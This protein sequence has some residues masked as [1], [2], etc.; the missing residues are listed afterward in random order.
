MKAFLEK[1]DL[2]C[3]YPEFVKTKFISYTWTL[4]R[5]NQNDKLKFLL[6]WISELKYEF[7]QG[8]F[9]K[10]FWDDYNWNLIHSLIFDFER[11]CNC[12]SRN[13]GVEF[14]FPNPDNLIKNVAPVYIYGAGKFA[15]KALKSLR[16]KEIKVTAFVVTDINNN[17]SSIDGIP[18]IELDKMD[19]DGLIYIGVSDKFKNEIIAL[20]KEKW[21][22]PNVFEI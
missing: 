11:T 12:I 20:L 16:E 21:L 19:K 22:L 3:F 4:A 15:L 18:V 8:Y 9:K 5:L 2:F 7:S 17:P 13:Q 1:N 14:N 6:K 10:E